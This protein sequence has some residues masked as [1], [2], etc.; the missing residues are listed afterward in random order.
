MGYHTLRPTG[1]E[2][3]YGLSGLKSVLWVQGPPVV[4]AGRG[5]EQ[6]SYH[7]RLEPTPRQMGYGTP[8]STLSAEQL[9]PAAKLV[10]RGSLLVRPAPACGAPA[11]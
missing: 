2:G 1:P 3:P 10:K 11:G 5:G 7:S 4:V 9:A 6:P 8:Q